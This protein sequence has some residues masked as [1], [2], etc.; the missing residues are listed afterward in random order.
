MVSSMSNERKTIFDSAWDRC[1]RT[2]EFDPRWSNGMGKYDYAV[3]GE[4][5]PKI[6]HGT[7]M[8]SST[9]CGR[10]LLL[11]G[12][13]L[14]VVVV[15]EHNITDNNHTDPIY[16][17]Q[18]TSHLEEGRWF[19]NNV[20]DEYELEIAVGTETTPHIGRIVETIYAGLKRSQ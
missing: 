7:M 6:P 10:K 15:F 18:S 20:L 16:C 5:V 4:H 19:S 3:Y 8:R 13:R 14:G 17:Y 9:P 12:T 11:I 1:T 2:L